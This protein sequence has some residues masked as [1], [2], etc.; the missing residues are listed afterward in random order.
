VPDRSLHQGLSRAQRLRKRSSFL[1]AQ[2]RGRRCTG[3]LLVVYAAS[4]EAGKNARI[5]RLG[6]TVSKKVG[7]AVVRNRVKRWVRESYRR[8]GA[9][10]P[11]AMDVVVIA[12]PSSAA[13][14]CAAI[15]GELRRLLILFRTP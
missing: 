2:E 12:K 13:S 6:I 14:T 11:S 15:E 1:S 8:L 5:S 3:R 7:G 10:S 4:T 9:T